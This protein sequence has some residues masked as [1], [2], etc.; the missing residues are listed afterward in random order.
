MTNLCD[1]IIS[2]PYPIFATVLH[3]IK[4]ILSVSFIRRN[5]STIELGT[6]RNF[7]LIEVNSFTIYT[8]LDYGP[9][10]R[11]FE[12]PDSLC[13]FLC[14]CCRLLFIIT[15]SIIC[16]FKSLRREPTS[17]WFSLIAFFFGVHLKVVGHWVSKWPKEQAVL[18]PRW[19][20]VVLYRNFTIELSCISKTTSSGKAPKAN[21]VVEQLAKPV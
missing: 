11:L 4:L 14:V 16:R 1:R 20:P 18:A 3:N 5:S 10:S 2:Y 21:N 19:L 17:H 7:S 15:T 9:L 8:Y 12:S 6:W 13:L